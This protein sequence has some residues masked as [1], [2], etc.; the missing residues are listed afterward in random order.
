[1]ITLANYI[2][3]AATAP[4][5]GQYL[6]GYNPATGKVETRVPDSQKEDIDTAVA[7][8]EAA[9]PAW[10]ATPAAE[11][12]AILMRIADGI[13]RRLDEFAL[14]ESR[15]QGKPVSLARQVEIP[16]AVTNFRFFAGAILHHK[17]DACSMDGDALNYTHRRPLGVAGLISPWN[18]P[19]YLLSWKIAPAIAVGNTCVAKPSELTS[20]TAHLL[21]EVMSEAGLPP[22]VCNIVMGRGPSAGAA[23]V[24][25]PR[26]PLISFTGGTATAQA[27][28]RDSAPY[29]KKLSLE[30]GGKNANIIFDD[31]DLELCIPT[32]IRSSFANQG[33]I[34]LCGSRIFVQRGI[35]DRFMEGFVAAA[36]QIKVGDPAANDTNMGALNSKLHLGKVMG[37]VALAREE[38]GTIVVG[39]DRPQLDEAFAEGYFMNPTIITGLD[40]QCRV[41]NEEIFGPVVTV[42]PFDSAEE[43]LGYANQN[44]Y[45]LSASVWTTNVH[46]AHSIAQ[47]LQA[48]VVWVNTWLMRD[49]RTPFGGM[50]ASGVGREGGK[51][52]ID[53]YTEVQN[54]CIK[55]EGVVPYAPMNTAAMTS[56]ATITKPKAAKAQAPAQ[57]T[58]M[59]QANGTGINTTKAPPPVGAYPHARREG[60]LLFLSGV[61]PRK[62]GTKEIPGVTFNEAGEVIA[63][64]AKAQTRSV[65]E[66]IQVILEASGSSLD[67]VVD[68]QCFLTNMKK[69]FKDFNEVYAEMLGPYGATRTTVEVGALPTPIAVEFKVIAKI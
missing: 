22:G 30:L 61:G 62:P 26:V 16:R 48:G 43:V 47:S 36:K 1:M 23:L 51:H 42:M 49:L 40:N 46:R 53:F 39:G 59:N 21:G 17:E 3:G 65:I 18:L 52:S 7:M 13:E 34:C 37:Y 56:P 50:K 14:A 63:E 15:D 27:I 5:H 41:M 31:A 6:D 64:D 69:H 12:S 67:K 32:T 35:Y 29:F 55:H 60:N 58:S 54:I 11:R 38:G 57:E 68:I 33:E 44:A 19:L 28:V 66:N 25:H 9:F 24:G 45:G 20:W 2:N 8:A 4:I 10:A